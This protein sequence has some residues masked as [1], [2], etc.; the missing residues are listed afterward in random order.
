MPHFSKLK[1]SCF[2]LAFSALLMSCS[3]S[4]PYVLSSASPAPSPSSEPPASQKEESTPE[5]SVSSEAPIL[6]SETPAAS[7]ETI[8]SSSEAV[9]SSQQQSSS[10]QQSLPPA[11]SSQ[12]QGSSSA[13]SSQQSSSSSESSSS[14]SSASSSSSSSSVIQTYTVTWKNDDGSVLRRDTKLKEGTVPYY[15]TTNP[16]KAS[17][18]QYTYTF[19]GWDPVIVPV[20]GNATYRAVYTPVLRTYKI[21]WKDDDGT[22]LKTDEAVPYGS[23]PSYGDSNPSK[24]QDQASVYDFETW[25]PALSEVKG[26]AT[27]VAKYTS[28]PRHY[29]ITW[30]D[31]NGEVLK[32][33]NDAEFGSTPTYSGELLPYD[34]PLDSTYEYVFTGWDPAVTSVTE[35]AIYTAVYAHQK[36]TVAIT[37]K[38]DDGS[39]IDTTNV[40][41]GEVPTHDDAT[42]ANTAQYTYTFTG[43]DPAPVAASVPATYTATFS[44]TVNKYTVTWKN[45]DGSVLE[46]DA[47]VAYGSTPT[48][49]GA[50]PT[51]PEDQTNTYTFKAWSRTITTVTQN[52]TYTATFDAEAKPVTIPD[53][54]YFTNGMGWGNVHAYA[55]NS[56]GNN[57]EWPGVLMSYHKTNE[58]NQQVLKI[59]GMSAYEKIIFNNGSDQTV[60]VV[61]ADLGT[62]NAYYLKNE[63]D[64]S[65]HYKVGTWYESGAQPIETKNYGMRIFHCFDWTLD[66]IKNNLAA[67]SAQGFNAI[68][69]SPL[70][71]VKDYNLNYEDTHDSWWAFY[72]PVSFSIANSTYNNLFKTGDGATELTALCQAAAGYGIRVIVDVVANHLGDNGSGGF[73][74]QVAQF[75]PNIYNNASTTLHH[76]NGGGGAVK[77]IVWANIT[78]VDLNTASGIV[79]GRVLD[80]LKQLIDCGVTGFRF[81]A[82]KHIETKNDSGCGSNFW[83]NTLGV[84]KTYATNK[85][86]PLFSYGEILNGTEGGRSYG[87]YL[88][89]AYLDAVTDSVIG[90]KARDNKDGEM[91]YYTGGL[92]GE[93]VVFGESHDEYMNH[94]DSGWAGQQQINYA[95]AK[96]ASK[97]V[98]S[99][100]LYFARPDTSKK[101]KDGGVGLNPEWGWKNGDVLKANL[102]HIG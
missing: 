6:S 1:R 96:L 4:D 49:D 82:A 55:W 21:T 61:L 59:T 101:S 102:A 66:T 51:K 5:A 71:A 78:C 86:M 85:E 88:S 16:A 30:K 91:Y 28:T 29:S 11:V 84:A 93:N 44:S 23:M 14:Q 22:V 35:D 64:T 37:W 2:L 39:T 41:L 52:A 13:S 73:H 20:S 97:D 10:T 27:Y 60:D 19:S 92:A 40:A 62:D 7:S 24:G 31:Q 80:Y 89:D 25:V 83:E 50:T 9:T 68:Q 48:Y 18:A 63:K 43:W 34:D 76:Y 57:H 79:Q 77:D 32:T 53:T 36:K 69:T 99:N 38:N 90:E 12:E 74:T 65:G 47:E 67:I 94:K 81:D 70:Q 75:E 17:D 26:N 95:Y 58:Y 3:T 15:G 100:L 42:K 87:Q 33:D 72:Q 46:T 98:Y 8:V 45:Y 54:I 56:K